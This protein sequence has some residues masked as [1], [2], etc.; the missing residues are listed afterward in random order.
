MPARGAL[1]TARGALLHAKGALMQVSGALL[2]ARGAL[3]PTLGA[4]LRYRPCCLVEGLSKTPRGFTAIH[5][6]SFLFKSC[7]HN[8]H[9]RKYSMNFYAKYVKILERKRRG[10]KSMYIILYVS[11]SKVNV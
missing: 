1:L 4:L 5:R 7:E 3:L 6:T 10:E 9:M 8:L 11:V 2:P